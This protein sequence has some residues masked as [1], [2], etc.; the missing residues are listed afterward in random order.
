MIYYGVITLFK[1]DKIQ[2]PRLVFI[3]KPLNYEYFLSYFRGKFIDILSIKGGVMY[4][5]QLNI[6]L[7]NFCKLNRT[8]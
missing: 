3:L 5:K 6:N 8:I 7:K 1:N 2:R 4:G